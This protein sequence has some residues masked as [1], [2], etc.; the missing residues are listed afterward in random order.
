[1]QKK[2]LFNI[3]FAFILYFSK[4]QH[5]DVDFFAGYHLS[6]YLYAATSGT[7]TIQGSYHFGVEG[8]Y[9]ISALNKVGLSAVFVSDKNL[10][11]RNFSYKDIN[12]FDNPRVEDS[13]KLQWM[14]IPVSLIHEFRKNKTLFYSASL[15]PKVNLNALRNGTAYLSGLTEHYSDKY[16]IDTKNGTS[17]GL[18]AGIS[19]G[20]N[21]FTNKI[22]KFSGRVF[23]ETDITKWR[24]RSNFNLEKEVY[25]PFRGIMAGFDIAY[26]L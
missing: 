4:A 6:N 5:I 11:K 17:L 2:L 1:M 3:L 21:P 18:A 9:K 13:Y 15:I 20:C 23:F 26:S 25:Y 7:R 16:K 12:F 10:V 24:Y 22:P 14:K 8:K 19:L